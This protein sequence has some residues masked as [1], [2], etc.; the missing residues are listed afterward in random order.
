VRFEDVQKSDVEALKVKAVDVFDRVLAKAG[1]EN[2]NARKA[3]IVAENMHQSCD[4][5]RVA[6]HKCGGGWRIGKSG[7]ELEK[8]IENDIGLF[9]GNDA[10]DVSV[11][12]E[13]CVVR[14][15]E[16]TGTLRRKAEEPDKE[17]LAFVGVLLFVQ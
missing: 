9:G 4:R 14:E 2:D 5:R 15:L 17:R 11:K 13:E 3:R 6:D 16:S 7:G 12:P 8:K 10:V 1:H